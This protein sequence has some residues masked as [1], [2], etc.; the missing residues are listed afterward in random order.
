MTDYIDF[1]KQEELTHNVVKGIYR[2]RRP[3]ISFKVNDIKKE[4]DKVFTIFQRYTNDKYLWCNDSYR[5]FA[6]TH[7]CF[8]DVPKMMKIMI[9]LNRLLLEN[10]IDID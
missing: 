3:F 4:E 10:I 1:L 9:F 5:T 8:G 2:Y 7:E 6:I